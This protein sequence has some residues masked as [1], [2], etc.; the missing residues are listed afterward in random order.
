M[1]PKMPDRPAGGDHWRQADARTESPSRS[2]LTSR[3]NKLQ[4]SVQKRVI[5]ADE[6]MRALFAR[7]KADMFEMTKLVNNT[8]SNPAA[9]PAKCGRERKARRVDPTGFFFARPVKC[10]ARLAYRL[11]DDRLWGAG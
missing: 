9:K 7:P 10:D 5:N 8:S 6:K 1:A 4:D 2:G 3:R 11:R